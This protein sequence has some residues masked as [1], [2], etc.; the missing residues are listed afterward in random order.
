MI[1]PSDQPNIAAQVL[2]GDIEAA[3]QHAHTQLDQ[4]VINWSPEQLQGIGRILDNTLPN[5]D[6]A[7][8][9]IEQNADPE[10]LESY[11]RT[12]T[13]LE[14][15]RQTDKSN[16]IYAGLENTADLEAAIRYD[17]QNR[18]L[19]QD[20]QLPIGLTRDMLE[21]NE[22]TGLI[23]IKPGTYGISADDEQAYNDY[24][25]L[26]AEIERTG[27]ELSGQDVRLSDSQ[28]EE[29]LEANIVQ[30]DDPFPLISGMFKLVENTQRYIKIGSGLALM[31]AE[32]TNMD[33]RW[34]PGFTEEEQIEWDRMINEKF[35]DMTRW[36]LQ[37]TNFNNPDLLNLLTTFTSK[38]QEEFQQL[39]RLREQFKPRIDQET[40]E[41]Y[42]PD[43][44]IAALREK[45]IDVDA[46]RLEDGQMSEDLWDI[47]L[48]AP[49][50]L[51]SDRTWTTEEF[52]RVRA[53]TRG[54]W[55]QD[56]NIL[57]RDAFQTAMRDRLVGD[58]HSAIMQEMVTDIPR[59]QMVREYRRAASVVT[60]RDELGLFSGI[61]WPWEGLQQEVVTDFPLE[62]SKIR[63]MR[64]G[65]QITPEEAYFLLEQVSEEAVAAEVFRDTT[66]VFFA[67]MMDSQYPGFSERHGIRD[68]ETFL[69]FIHT[70]PSRDLTP[71]QIVLM[72]GTL[73]IIE[74]KAKDVMSTQADSAIDRVRDTKIAGW[75]QALEAGNSSVAKDKSSNSVTNALFGSIDLA[76][77]IAN[78]NREALDVY[79]A[80]VAL[81]SD[82]YTK[83]LRTLAGDT[84]EEVPLQYL[85]VT[86]DYL[87]GK[88]INID[89]ENISPAERTASILTILELSSLHRNGPEP[90]VVDS[91]RTWIQ[92]SVNN[93]RPDTLEG[94]IDTDELANIAGALSFLEEM[95]KRSIDDQSMDAFRKIFTGIPD[96]QWDA[97]MFLNQADVLGDLGLSTTE[98]YLRPLSMQGNEPP[99]EDQ[100]QEHQ[101]ARAKIL[102]NIQAAFSDRAA[103]MLVM[104]IHQ[105][106]NP[107]RQDDRISRFKRGDMQIVRIG[108]ASSFEELKTI[109]NKA[110]S[111]SIDPG[112]KAITHWH[113]MMDLLDQSNWIMPADKDQ[114]REVLEAMLP[115]K[116]GDEPYGSDMWNDIFKNDTLE[117][118]QMGIMFRLAEHLEFT[119][120]QE[121]AT[122]IG[123]WTRMLLDAPT[124]LGIRDPFMMEKLPPLL[125]SMHGI[126][127]NQS[128]NNI[129]IGGQEYLMTP[130]NST[131]FRNSDLRSRVSFPIRTGIGQS[132][133]IDLEP[134]SDPLNGLTNEANFLDI[135]PIDLMR[136]AT[137]YGEVNQIFGGD[138]GLESVLEFNPD[139]PPVKVEGFRDFLLSHFDQTHPEFRRVQSLWVEHERARLTQ[140][141]R[142]E[143][144]KWVPGEGFVRLDA[145][146]QN[147]AINRMDPDHE[148]Y[149]LSLDPVTFE[150]LVRGVVSDYMWYM[151]TQERR[152]GLF[153]ERRDLFVKRIREQNP[154]WTEEEVNK[155][156]DATFEEMKNTEITMGDLLYEVIYRMLPESR[157]FEPSNDANLSYG[158]MGISRGTLGI[159]KSVDR[160][161][162][163][164]SG[165]SALYRENGIIEPPRYQGI[166]SYGLTYH[167]REPEDTPLFSVRGGGRDGSPLNIL[168]NLN[169]APLGPNLP[170]Q[171]TAPVPFLRIYLRGHK[172]DVTHSVWP[173]EGMTNRGLMNYSLDNDIY[174]QS[175]IR[176][177]NR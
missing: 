63:A 116:T 45:G 168:L 161:L 50:V 30:D 163:L 132:R 64:S 53:E 159:R 126:A 157:P 60:S 107:V 41:V 47:Y 106:G 137:T 174:V 103:K 112:D 128:M 129:S 33:E 56:E 171:S 100:I 156:W 153:S 81:V 10:N 139:H 109:F 18:N 6:N 4:A 155:T 71:N 140:Y 145:A 111:S 52:Q 90:E 72:K 130:Q 32:I 61:V 123:N 110:I 21:T 13:A 149:N 150:R 28:S 69:E 108:R 160:P 77:D 122:P 134:Y 76:T 29:L 7:L 101:G 9:R 176:N 104:A 124:E 152:L 46:L 118:Y 92:T 1:N 167:K 147:A 16:P 170:T 48:S 143:A 88:P 8:W 165:L 65:D 3:L 68:A 43:N 125:K 26:V 40:G 121:G 99:T 115:K 73:K 114:A 35:L 78:G 42:L 89:W 74:E 51:A 98:I 141:I 83:H 166:N 5:L 142:D 38:T 59:E 23:Q 87:D 136:Q 36:A 96:S 105:S 93:F 177:T 67:E 31:G 17:I 162:I 86:Q 158:F 49:T 148:D 24:F 95:S 70:Y 91:L 164:G 12:R 135:R 57:L 55:D 20:S 127:L 58:L 119:R 133:S 172:K 173:S 85:P 154:E 54:T 120:S 22:E 146:E 169:N 151:N 102:Q 37:D 175:N 11:E 131:S 66:P 138:S 15:I 39:V 44:M 2:S 113:Y 14:V 94:D 80:G 34:D 144:T 25:K 97:L 62:T 19:D 82:V 84:E 75:T 117:A 27:S 79:R